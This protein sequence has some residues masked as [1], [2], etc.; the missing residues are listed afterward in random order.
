MGELGFNKI[1]GSILA[2]A[3]GVMG[4]QAVTSIVFSSGGHHG[5]HGEKKPFCESVKDDNAYWVDVPC[6]GSSVADDGPVYDLGLLLASADAAKG[7]RVFKSVCSS[8]HTIDAGGANGTGPNLHGIINSDIARTAGFG[9]SGALSGVEGNW[10]YEQMDSWIMDPSNIARGVNMVANVKRDPDR[11]NLIAYLAANTPD[12]PAFPDP[13]PAEGEAPLEDG[14]EPV[15]AEEAIDSV[16]EAIME[17]P[18]AVE[19]PEVVAPEEGEAAL[20]EM[21]TIVE[22]ME[23]GVDRLDAIIED[24]DAS[25]E[26]EVSDIVETVEDA[27]DTV[28]TPELAVEDV[29]PPQ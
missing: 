14:V 27:A 23:D 16:E 3:L 21:E 15:S 20:D 8:C 4:L 19:V 7:E 17:E 10:T 25:L 24:A 26:P 12:A 11:A 1:F 13:L 18:V 6:A 5:H 29:L 9:Y 22:R 2:A 28:E